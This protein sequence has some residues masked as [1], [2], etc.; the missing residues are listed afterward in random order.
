MVVILQPQENSQYLQRLAYNT[1]RSK[2]IV[3][4]P[5]SVDTRFFS[6]SKRTEDKTT[7]KILFV[8]RLNKQ[9]GLDCLLEAIAKLIKMHLRKDFFVEIIGDGRQRPDLT[10]KSES[11]RIMNKVTFVGWLDKIRLLA[12]YQSADIFISPSL[13]EGMPNVIMEAMACGLP[14]IASDIPAH[15]EF[16]TQDI[17]GVLVP[18]NDSGALARAFKMLIEDERLRRRMGQENL[19]YIAQYSIFNME[20]FFSKVIAPT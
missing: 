1:L 20:R 8:G 19:D 6:A 7:V 4:I 18:L 17:H 14:I 11:L 12:H 13:D 2:P 10:R 3:V 15:K 5:N 9:K 16:I